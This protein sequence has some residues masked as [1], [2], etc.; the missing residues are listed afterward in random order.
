MAAKDKL[1]AFSPIPAF[2]VASVVIGLL[3][4]AF[5][6]VPQAAPSAEARP[7]SGTSAETGTAEAAKLCA[8]AK[9]PRT[10]LLEYLRAR[11]AEFGPETAF[12]DLKVLY[13][14]DENAHGFC[15]QLAHEI[16]HGGYKKYGSVAAAFAHGDN[17]CWSGYHHGVLESYVQDIGMEQLPAKLGHVCDDVPGRDQYTFGYFNCVHGLG[18]GLMAVTDDKVADALQYCDNLERS[19]D[20]DS[21]YGGVFMQNVINEDL[22]LHVPDFKKDDPYYPCDAVGDKYKDSCYRMQ[23]S[24]MLKV[25]DRDFSKIFAAC[26]ATPDTREIDVCYASLGRDA[27]GSTVS[28][29][30]KTKAL[31]MLGKDERQRKG[32]FEGAVKDF[33]SFHHSDV[34]AKELCATLD[35]D[36][37]GY[38]LGVAKDYYAVFEK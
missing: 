22:T 34:E 4:A 1:P 27:S 7:S 10:C 25:M 38:C 12:A 29:V 32:C 6:P 14:K 8:R 37:R 33:I 24:H 5:A 9:A 17:F 28:D 21:C 15:H 35:D 2:F 20:K 11:T 31:C 26:A 16:G 19:W 36:L 3:A 23:T 30:A 13:D 18:H